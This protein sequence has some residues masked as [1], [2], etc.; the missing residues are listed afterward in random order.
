MSD[1]AVT[2]TKSDYMSPVLRL[3]QRLV[4]NLQGN[5]TFCL[6]LIDTLD[7]LNSF[8]PHRK[9]EPCSEMFCLESSTEKFSFSFSFDLSILV[10]ILTTLENEHCSEAPANIGLEPAEKLYVQF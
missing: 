7:F 2:W 6:V 9:N 5:L 1:W 10:L 8:Q 3:P 4:K